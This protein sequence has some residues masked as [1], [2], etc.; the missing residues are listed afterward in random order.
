MCTHTLNCIIELFKVVTI[1]CFKYKIWK[2]TFLDHE[3]WNSRVIYSYSM[4]RLL[5]CFIFRIKT[6]DRLAGSRAP[7]WL[8]MSGE[9][10]WVSQW[11]ERKRTPADRKN[12]MAVTY[13]PESCLLNS[14]TLTGDSHWNAFNCY[15]SALQCIDKVRVSLCVEE[16]QREESER[17]KW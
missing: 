17:R 16:R 3:C 14:T 7:D 6:V 1:L 2:Y 15:Q 5:F 4:S 10:N 9:G 12:N 13:R 11:E 8:L